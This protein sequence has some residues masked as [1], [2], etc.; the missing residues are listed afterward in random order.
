MICCRR[1]ARSSLSYPCIAVVV[2]ASQLCVLIFYFF[3][4]FFFQSW[5]WFHS[6]RLLDIVS[7]AMCLWDCVNNRL[8]SILSRRRGPFGIDKWRLYDKIIPPTTPA[9]T[10]CAIP[11]WRIHIEMLHI[12]DCFFVYNDLISSLSSL[13]SHFSPLSV[14]RCMPVGECHLW[15]LVSS[16]QLCHKRICPTCNMVMRWGGTPTNH[17]GSCYSPVLCILPRL[18]PNCPTSSQFLMPF[19]GLWWPWLP[20]VMVTWRT[21][22][23]HFDFSPTAS[24]F[25]HQ[26][27]ILLP[28]LITFYTDFLHV[29]IRT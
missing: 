20:S 3:W 5:F 6:E 23:N 4:F 15:N 10:P 19:G 26:R 18:I 22:P 29:L 2:V 16:S 25:F 11:S 14:H 24:F 21:E 27:L 13:P 12:W 28:S 1:L 9:F 7:C 17:Q 8:V